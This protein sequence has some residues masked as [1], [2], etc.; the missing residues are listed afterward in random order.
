MRNDVVPGEALA[1]GPMSRVLR[2]NGMFRAAADEDGDFVYRLQEQRLPIADSTAA[3]MPFLREDW[4]LISVT[5][6]EAD[7]HDPESGIF[8]N[9]EQRW[10]V[11]AQISYFEGEELITQMP[12]GLRLHGNSTR[13]PEVRAKYGASVRLYARETYGDD[14]LPLEQIFDGEAAPATRLII[15]GESALSSAL[16]FDIVR[17][18]GGSAPE[19]RPGLYVLNGEVQGMFSLSEHLTKDYWA[20]ELGH[21]DFS[22]YRYRGNSSKADAG[23]YEDLHGW[24]ARLEP[25]DVTMAK[26]GE[27]VDLESFIRHMFPILWCGT[28]DWAQGAAYLDRGPRFQLWRWVNWDMDRSFRH[29]TGNDASNSEVW[30]KMC[31]DLVLADLS[32]D[33][34]ISNELKEANRVQREDARCLIFAGL[35]RDDPKFNDVFAERAMGFMNHELGADFLSERYDWYLQFGGKPGIAP[36][37]LDTAK[38]FLRRRSAFFRE[39]MARVFGL[40]DSFPVRVAAGPGEEQTLMIDGRLEALPY[41]GYYFPGQTITVEVPGLVK[42]EGD[43]ER[44]WRVGS[45]LVEGARLELRVEAKVEIRAL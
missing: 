38:L 24:V 18:I 14:D 8:A 7:L 27:N 23:N 15:R 17:K 6:N 43:L 42:A 11:P 26:V 34:A 45:K 3:A 12:V 37:A 35:V 44:T 32:A 21:G 4:P 29:S 13:R 33:P 31:F 20:E 28:D 41:V 36:R 30:R 2:T 39:D 19:M 25:G 40:G 10:E 16:S 9:Y 22:F 5:V 1:T